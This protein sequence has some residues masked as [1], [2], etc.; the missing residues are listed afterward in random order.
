MA[1]KMKNASGAG[2]MY[3]T[4]NYGVM[5]LTNPN[6]LYQP[7]G[8]IQPI[9]CDV[10]LV[11]AGA[12]IVM[13]VNDSYAYRVVIGYIDEN[14]NTVLSPP[15][16]RVILAATAANTYKIV[17]T[18][19]INGNPATTWFYRVYRSKKKTGTSSSYIDPGDELYL[20]YQNLFT[21]ANLL[22]R[23][24]QIDDIRADEILGEPL[25]TNPSRETSTN[26]NFPPPYCRALTFFKNHM[27]YMN[28][29]Q[30]HTLSVQIIGTT[31]ASGATITIAGS[32][33]T[34]ANTATTDITLVQDGVSPAGE[35]KNTG[36]FVRYNL[37]TDI[38]QRIEGTARSLCRVIN[39]YP[40][41]NSVYAY[42]DSEAGGSPG[43]I[44]IMERQL[45]GS[46]FSI[47]VDSNSTGLN[48]EPILP[49]SGTSIS[50]TNNEAVAGCYISKPEQPDHVPLYT[51]KVIGDRTE[52]IN[53]VFSLKDSIIVIKEN[54]VWRGSGSSLK[55]FAFSILDNTVA[56]R[57]S[58]EACA[59]LDNKVYGISN[60]GP[61]SIS[62]TGIELI[63]RAEEYNIMKGI[64]GFSDGFSNGI[65]VDHKN[66][67]LV[68]TY[69]PE[70]KQK[71]I[72]NPASYP[73]P[74]STFAYN[75]ATGTWSRYLINASTF[76]VLNDR[77]YYGLNNSKGIIM[78]E[79]KQTVAD[80]TNYYDETSTVNITAINTATNT[81]NLTFTKGVDYDGY[82]NQWAYLNELS[83][84]FENLSKGWVIQDSVRQYVVLSY[85]S[86]A[87]TA[88]VH[89][90]TGLTNGTKNVYRPIPVTVEYTPSYADNASVI[91]K[92]REIVLYGDFN[93]CYDLIF[94][95]MNPNDYKDFR[96]YYTW[97]PANV[98][99]ITKPLNDI[100]NKN[101]MTFYDKFVREQVPKEKWEE[102][103]LSFRVSN[104]TANGSFIVKGLCI[105]LDAEDSVKL[106]R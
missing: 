34:A 36:T 92:F 53:H 63:G 72:A 15:S 46:S 74:Y 103:Y 41:N 18:V 81:I 106:R 8:I 50:S 16:N 26:A 6:S 62:E 33:Y 49:T 23:L 17:V 54:S 71:N 45:G 94:D 95:F 97:N 25:Y 30:R 96:H 87:G 21:N 86:G 47:T 42:Y 75:Y 5:R 38:S 89:T 52:R 28:C 12:G 64:L 20:D 83:S 9:E 11:A 4:S 37:V 78:E 43:I 13:E 82:F 22:A 48:F 65:G 51:F 59:I 60:G 40:A 101:A 7:A 66:L 68:C 3:F 104:V 67:Y 79:R 76:A 39:G 27:F 77:V 93:N 14:N 85:N 2:N 105:Q 99:R 55:G 70:L 73:Y 102:A 61:V 91:K 19:R 100:T 88:V 69:D 98:K 32:T 24:V 10:R 1:Y 44:R 80:E 58:Y 90:T 31:I 56:I 84:G 29:L 57:D 35:D